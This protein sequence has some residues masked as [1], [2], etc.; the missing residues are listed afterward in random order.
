MVF[1][2]SQHEIYHRTLIWAGLNLTYPTDILYQ[3]VKYK[4]NERCLKIQGIKSIVFE[5]PSLLSIWTGAAS[6]TQVL[7]QES[8]FEYFL[9]YCFIEYLKQFTV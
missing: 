2:R 4:I 3:S 9:T 7:H 8:T 6:I 5:F 1:F